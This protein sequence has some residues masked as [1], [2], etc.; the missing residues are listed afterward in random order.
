MRYSPCMSQAE[1]PRVEHAALAEPEETAYRGPRNLAA[2]LRIGLPVAAIYVVVYF[3]T[4]W[5]T[6]HRATHYRLYF[7]AELAIP[8]MPGMI[9]LYASILL[10][11]FLP[12]IR[13]TPVEM[14]ALARAM[15]ATLLLAALCF[16]LF[17][18]SLGFERPGYVPGYN[19]VY[20]ALYR[21]EMP[22][23]LVPSLHVASSIL[24]IAALYGCSTSGWARLA[25]LLW[26]ILIVASVLLVHQHHLLDVVT[27]LLLGGLG[28]RYIYLPAIPRRGHE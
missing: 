24:F 25:L 19:A 21:L 12:A 16:L 14:R 11:V 27:G 10:L 2:Y 18:A 1:E 15:L 7:E 8:F 9:Y 17:P 5:L 20:Q 28:Y 4:N 6:A 23:N 26:A 3:G 13:L 22:Y